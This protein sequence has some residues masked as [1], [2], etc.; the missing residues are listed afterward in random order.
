MTCP[1]C[2]YCDAVQDTHRKNHRDSELGPLV[3]AKFR[4]GRPVRRVGVHDP[5]PLQH[6][7]MSLHRSWA[8]ATGNS[9][10]AIHHPL[11]NGQKRPAHFDDGGLCSYILVRDKYAVASITVAPVDDCQLLFADG[12][13]SDEWVT[14]GRWT[15]SSLFVARSQRRSG[16]ARELIDGFAT[17]SGTTIPELCWQLP[18]TTDGE[19]LARA[20]SGPG[21]LHVN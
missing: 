15:I 12:T 5:V 9:A 7:A 2:G 6:A 21:P 4:A 18:F 13:M 20:L 17:S 3:P 10:W 1:D 16:A 19:A 8:R 11:P 14:G